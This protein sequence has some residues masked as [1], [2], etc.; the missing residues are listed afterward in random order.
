MRGMIGRRDAS[1]DETTAGATWLPGS[2]SPT[3]ASDCPPPPQS[4]D[5]SRYPILLIYRPCKY[6]RVNT[7]M[8]THIPAF[9]PPSLGPLVAPPHVIR[10]RILNPHSP[11]FPS[12][13]LYDPKS[14]LIS[15]V[16]SPSP[17]LLA[18]SSKSNAIINPGPFSPHGV[19]P[20]RTGA[21]IICG[22]ERETFFM[23]PLR[24]KLRA[25]GAPATP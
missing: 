16:S 11:H 7:P 17:H 1:I 20:G 24:K 18:L 3:L 25:F 12:I 22:E 6:L 23:Y 9:L 10:L 4:L 13:A 5:C 8:M 21:A 15:A 2:E 14:C 19:K